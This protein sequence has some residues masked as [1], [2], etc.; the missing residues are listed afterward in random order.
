MRSFGK[1]RAAWVLVGLAVSSCARTASTSTTPAPAP[2]RDIEVPFR[3]TP[4]LTKEDG[5]AIADVTKTKL[6]RMEHIAFVKQVPC[7]MVECGEGIDIRAEATVLSKRSDVTDVIYLCK[8]QGRWFSVR[9]G[10]KEQDSEC[11]DPTRKMPETTP[12]KVI[13][14]EQAVAFAEDFL[15][16]K[17]YGYRFDRRIPE[18]KSPGW[19]TVIFCEPGYEQD[20]RRVGHA[21]VIMEILGNRVRLQ[22]K[23]MFLDSAHTR[24]R[25]CGP[26]R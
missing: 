14:A 8:R 5:L 17:A 4:P 22:E 10:E 25:E 15:N 19:W 16:A 18:G 7:P 24:L 3:V 13:S 2:I 9:L 20:G 26:L 1:T 23:G 12:A 11:P 6:R 21:V